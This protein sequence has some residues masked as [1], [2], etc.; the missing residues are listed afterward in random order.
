MTQ[1]FSVHPLMLFPPPPSRKKIQPAIQNQGLYSRW[2]WNPL[3]QLKCHQG[4]PNKGQK[5][6]VSINHQSHI[7]GE[8]FSSVQWYHYRVHG[9]ETN[10]LQG[11][12]KK[13]TEVALR[14]RHSRNIQRAETAK[15][16]GSHNISQYHCSSFSEQSALWANLIMEKETGQVG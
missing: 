14:E 12:R 4:A 13:Q 2:R 10:Q 7:P 5:S 11:G 1:G 15:T 6:C 8:T 3:L 16:A 9:S